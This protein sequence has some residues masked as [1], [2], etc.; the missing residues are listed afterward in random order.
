MAN[1]TATNSL[2]GLQT[3]TLFTAPTTGSY[4]VN[5][6][7]TLPVLRDVGP[8]GGGGSQVV[9][10]VKDAATTVYTGIAGATG[11]QTTFTATAGDV[12]TLVLSSAAAPDQLLNAVRGVVGSGNAF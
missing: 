11:F 6:Q 3:T 12:I 7:L 10:V 5:G 1:F 2:N 8:S 4:F 9:A